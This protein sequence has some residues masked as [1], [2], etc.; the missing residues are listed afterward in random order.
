MIR[1]PSKR[2]RRVL[3]RR[4]QRSVVASSLKVTNAKPVQC[5]CRLSRA[6]NLEGRYRGDVGDIQGR[7]MGD[8][9]EMLLEQGSQPRIPL[10]DLTASLGQPRLARAR[11]GVRVRVRV[12]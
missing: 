2:G 5:R 4:M 6:R 8:A 12:L 9:R 10:R 11:V 1:A 3:I 7:Y